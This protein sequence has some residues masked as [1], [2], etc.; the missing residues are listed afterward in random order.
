VGF[1]PREA[2]MIVDVQNDFTPGGALPVL[3]GD[4]VIPPIN[5][6]SVRFDRVLA[7]QDW[8]PAHHCSFA[9]QNPGHIVGETIEIGGVLQRLW[10]DHCVQNTGGA[11]FAATLETRRIQH[12]FQKGIDPRYESYST[13][14]DMGRQS[15][16]LIEFLR[17]CGVSRLW[18]AGLAL[19]YCVLYSAQDARHCGLEVMLVRDACRAIDARQERHVYEALRS[20]GVRVISTSEL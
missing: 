3:G 16:G 1:G 8:H 14:F 15:T 19:D 12:V 17:T 6:A 7:S 11:L 4:E 20:I 9:S 10:P 5:S 18:F 2:L 13:F